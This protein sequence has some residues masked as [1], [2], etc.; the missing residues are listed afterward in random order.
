VALL[1]ELRGGSGP[2]AALEISSVDGF[3]GRE[4]EAV[5]ISMVRSNDKGGWRRLGKVP[6]CVVLCVLLWLVRAACCVLDSPA[7]SSVIH[8]I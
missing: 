7:A 1:R 2:L 8:G 4:K 6:C 5:V 3:Q